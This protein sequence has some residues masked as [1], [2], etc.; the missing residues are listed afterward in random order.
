M[1]EWGD[2]FTA[3]QKLALSTVSKFVALSD[4]QRLKSVLG[5]VMGRCAD[6]WSS[7]AMWAQEGEFVA[8]T[9]GRQALPIV[10]DYV[11][12]APWSD[13]SGNFI[14]AVDWVSRV[15]ETCVTGPVAQVQ[16][17]DAMSFPLPDEVSSFWFTDP[18]YYDAVP[19]ADLSDFFYVWLKRA[20]PGHPLLRDPWDITNRLTPKAHEIV[21]DET[22]QI[23]NRTKDRVFFED[24]MKL[25][26]A[27]GRR[28]TRENGIGA[29][30]FA[31]K[32]TEGVGSTAHWYD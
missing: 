3:R 22:K 23:D 10:W 7:G 29:V 12:A 32:T 27:E 11:E 25:A 24:A 14:G 4:D 13:S 19:Y 9:F 17:A 31:H 26:F 16:V 8:H 5:C 1:T 30:V 2:L 15:I 28:V 6:Y 18:P 21:Q 20:L